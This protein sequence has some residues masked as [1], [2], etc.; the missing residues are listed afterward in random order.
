M[1][2]RHELGTVE[3]MS[4][5]VQASPMSDAAFALEVWHGLNPALSWLLIGAGIVLFLIAITLLLVVVF[6]A[7]KGNYDGVD[8]RSVTGF[9]VM[10]TATFAMFSAAYAEGSVLRAPSVSD[11]VNKVDTAL[12][13]KYEILEA[14]PAEMLDHKG[15]VSDLVDDNPFTEA[16]ARVYLPYEVKKEFGL[17]GDDPI[18]YTVTYDRS[19]AELSLVKGLSEGAP[20]PKELIQDQDQEQENE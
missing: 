2:Y 19:T 17:H 5:P 6:R 10:L 18:I 9:L 7:D 1:L 13:S 3:A 4:T 16:T 12:A 15:F 11:T 20:A 8:W 14:H